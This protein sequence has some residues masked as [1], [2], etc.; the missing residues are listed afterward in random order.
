MHIRIS[1]ETY[2]DII[3]ILNLD[4]NRINVILLLEGKTFTF[5]TIKASHERKKRSKRI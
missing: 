2:Y 4:D 3:S 1:I 5:V